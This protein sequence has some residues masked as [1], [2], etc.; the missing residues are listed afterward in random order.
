MGGGGGGDGGGFY[1]YLTYNDILTFKIFSVTSSIFFLDIFLNNFL[2]FFKGTPRWHLQ[3][4]EETLY[5]LIKYT[6]TAAEDRTWVP[7]W[8]PSTEYLHI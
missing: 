5:L 3:F 1:E 8:E 2:S 7:R 6:E 4:Y